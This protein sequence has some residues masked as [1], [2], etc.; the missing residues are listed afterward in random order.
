[1]LLRKPSADSYGPVVALTGQFHARDCSIRWP[2]WSLRP[3]GQK[4]I[5]DVLDVSLAAEL[6]IDPTHTWVNVSLVYV[7]AIV[8]VPHLTAA[9]LS[10]YQPGPCS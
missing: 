1:V 8:Q 6:L 7:R 9:W 3:R 5:H 4:L 2:D 10:T